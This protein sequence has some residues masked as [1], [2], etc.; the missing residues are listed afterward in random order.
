MP[1]ADRDRPRVVR[2]KALPRFSAPWRS[3]KEPDA[4]TRIEVGD[5]LSIRAWLGRVIEGDPAL[6]N[7]MMRDLGILAPWQVV[8]VFGT[9]E[10]ML[11]LVPQPVIATMLLFPAT[12][13]TDRA[14]AEQMARAERNGANERLSERLVFIRQYVENACGPIALAHAVANTLEPVELDE[15]GFLAR[16]LRATEGLDG[17][18]RGKQLGN[19]ETLGV[20]ELSDEEK[21]AL[22]ER[23]DGDGEDKD[24]DGQ[25]KDADGEAQFRNR[26]CFH[27]VTFVVVDDELYEL[28][29]RKR[30][31]IAHGPSTAATLLQDSAAVMRNVMERDAGLEFHMLAVTRG[32]A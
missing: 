5:Y 6:L 1:Q 12:A 18:A 9:C 10:A 28:D 20:R 22:A 31:P 25:A 24:A 14:A 11:A 4:T 15:D 19:D 23:D 2:K 21:A 8:D 27:F 17:D 29:G 3:R 32:G 7:G 16:F 26:Q 13:K 30:F